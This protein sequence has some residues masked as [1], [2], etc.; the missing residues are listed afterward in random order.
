MASF[1]YAGINRI[2]FWGLISGS[3]NATTPKERDPVY[4]IMVPNV[5]ETLNN[6]FSRTSRIW[7]L[8]PAGPRLLNGVGEL[9]HRQVLLWFTHN[10]NANGK[11]VLRKS[12][13]Q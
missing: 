9:Q 3:Y 8:L 13:W 12:E 5:L 10:L 2:R 7:R 1:S 4:P 11:P 6:G